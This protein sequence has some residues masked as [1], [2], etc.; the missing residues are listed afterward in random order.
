MQR[1]TCV[2]GSFELYKCIPK[3]RSEKKISIHI[4]IS[5]KMHLHTEYRICTIQWAS[6][7][8]I[9]NNKIEEREA[10]KY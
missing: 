4:E 8:E 2:S 6:T 1:D 9:F 3:I 7:I 5:H 10:I